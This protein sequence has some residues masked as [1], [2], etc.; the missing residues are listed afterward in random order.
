MIY[1][2]KCAALFDI[3][4]SQRIALFIGKIGKWEKN[5]WCQATL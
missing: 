3:E 2:N 5:S 1:K 4:I